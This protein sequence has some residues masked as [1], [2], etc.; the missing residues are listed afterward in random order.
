MSV[1]YSS[2]IGSVPHNRTKALDFDISI[3]SLSPRWQPETI[4][5]GGGGIMQR[6]W[7]NRILS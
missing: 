5:E 4:R 6:T 1:I 7:K 3:V 2:S